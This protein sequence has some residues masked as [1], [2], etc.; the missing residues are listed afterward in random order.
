MIAMKVRKLMWPFK[1]KEKPLISRTVYRVAYVPSARVSN[2]KVEFDLENMHTVFVEADDIVDAQVAFAKMF[3]L[4]PHVYIHRIEK[5][6][7]IEA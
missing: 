1:K 4:T 6:I 7:T 5:A 3:I 2:G